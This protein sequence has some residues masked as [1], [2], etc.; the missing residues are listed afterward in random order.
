MI[1]LV[2]IFPIIACLILFLIKNRALNDFMITLYALIHLI[3]SVCLCA[4]YNPIDIKQNLFA[5]D[6]LNRVFL[7]VLSV[8]YLAVAVYNNGYMK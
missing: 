1:S 2:L 8:V 7:I 3:C 4:D 6:E 5:V